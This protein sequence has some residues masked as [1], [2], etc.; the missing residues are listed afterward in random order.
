MIQKPNIT[1]TA[2]IARSA[3][4]P[5][6]HAP[7]ARRYAASGLDCSVRPSNV[8]DHAVDASLAMSEN[9]IPPSQKISH[10][11][12]LTLPSRSD[13]R[14]ATTQRTLVA[15]LR[16]RP[17]HRWSSRAHP[18]HG[19]RLRARMPGADTSI[20]GIRVARELDPTGSSPIA[21][22]RRGSSATTVP[23]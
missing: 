3:S 18:G 19:R 20:S 9:E 2:M 17:V 10:T 23:S 4:S 6:S 8:V 21:V 11:K 5:S 15:R 1:A 13:A 22:S 7:A 12:L 14:T 16:R